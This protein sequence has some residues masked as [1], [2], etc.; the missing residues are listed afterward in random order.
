M[1][2]Y[3]DLRHVPSTVVEQIKCNLKT[4]LLSGQVTSLHLLLGVS[5]LV[6]CV[7]LL[8]PGMFDSDP[9]TYKVMAALL[10][11]HV[12]SLF[13]FTAGIVSILSL[14]LD[15]RTKI[16]LMAGSMLT[17]LVWTAATLC[18]MAAWWP[19]H[20]PGFLSQVA[21]YRVPSILSGP[22][23]LTLASWFAFVHY[24]A[25]RRGTIRQ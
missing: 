16:T 4:I 22:I 19:V 13:F 9:D 11:A 15:V 25:D 8:S 3:D 24:A 17:G 20:I 5:S 21:A 1:I 18:C 2:T 10:P 12:W 6:W 7:T 14:L 23:G